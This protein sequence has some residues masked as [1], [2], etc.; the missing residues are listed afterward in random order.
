M[1]IQLLVCVLACLF[2]V[3]VAAT[4]DYD[5]KSGGGGGK[6]G[7]KKKDSKKKKKDL[8]DYS[9]YEISKIY[10]EWRDNDPDRPQDDDDEDDDWRQQR[11][12][13]NF[14]INK[15]KGSGKDIVGSF[16]KKGKSLMMFVTVSGEGV[17]KD[18]AEKI[19]GIWQSSLFNANYEVTRYMFEDNKAIFMLK[20]GGFAY[21]I[22]DYLI[23]QERCLEVEIDKE[24]YKGI[25][26]DNSKKAEL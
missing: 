3:V 7:G 15:L 6:K 12:P 17:S 13:M 25:H 23:K 21:E 22:K 14:D 19:T 18:E 5:K 9:E 20:D 26:H 11:K 16:N 4:D 24:I 2:L 8:T 1:K 10:E